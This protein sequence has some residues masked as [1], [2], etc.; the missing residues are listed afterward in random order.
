MQLE[1]VRY[2]SAAG[3]YVQLHLAQCRMLHRVPISTLEHHLDPA[4]FVRVHR[5]VLVRLVSFSEIDA[6]TTVT[7]RATACVSSK[8]LRHFCTY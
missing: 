1:E 2:I 8:K 7:Y 6:I 5:S 3:N 4:I